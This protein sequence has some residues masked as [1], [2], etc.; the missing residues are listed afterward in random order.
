[1]VNLCQADSSAENQNGTPL[2]SAIYRL[3]GEIKRTLLATE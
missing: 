3:P 2:F 1:M